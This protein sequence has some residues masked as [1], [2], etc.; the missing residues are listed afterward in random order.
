[1]ILLFWEKSFKS[2]EA[3]YSNHLASP[4]VASC[5]EFLLLPEY[6][7]TRLSL[8]TRDV[9]SWAPRNRQ[10]QGCDTQDSTSPQRTCLIG[11]CKDMMSKMDPMRALGMQEEATETSLVTRKFSSSISRRKGLHKLEEDEGKNTKEKPWLLHFGASGKSL[12]SA[13]YSHKGAYW[14][15]LVNQQCSFHGCSQRCNNADSPNSDAPCEHWIKSRT[16]R[17]LFL[18]YFWCNQCGRF[19]CIIFLG[20]YP[21]KMSFWIPDLMNPANNLKDKIWCHVLNP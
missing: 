7:V 10:P 14:G 17:V 9:S 4:L 19:N 21:K 13:F 11:I 12:S 5:G 16:F 2:L 1:M 20:F 6:V 18:N 15:E 8:L 3:N